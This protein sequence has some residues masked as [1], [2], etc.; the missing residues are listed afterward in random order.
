MSFSSFIKRHKFAVAVASVVIIILIAFITFIIV[1]AVLWSDGD[2]KRDKAI[3]IARKEFGC[4]KVLWICH[5]N[6]SDFIDKASNRENV[7]FGKYAFCIV[8]QKEGEEIFIIIPAEYKRDK[9]YIATWPFDYSFTQ[10]AEKFIELGAPY[11]EKEFEKYPNLIDFEDKED[12]IK[13]ESAYYYDVAG[14]SSDVFYSRL[15]VKAIFSA[16]WESDNRIFN[17]IVTQENGELKAY[18]R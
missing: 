5:T 14:V 12:M 17:C 2:V 15:D 6:G 3:S 11:V 18:V 13:R 9:P 8:G 1:M 4:E 7:D 10:I 16:R